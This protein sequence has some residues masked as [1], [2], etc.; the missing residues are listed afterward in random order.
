MWP[1]SQPPQEKMLQTMGSQH[2]DVFFVIYGHWFLHLSKLVCFHDLTPFCGVRK[3]SKRIFMSWL[4]IVLQEETFNSELFPMDFINSE[5]PSNTLFRF[6][7]LYFMFMGVSPACMSVH[8]VYAWYL[9]TSEEGIGS[10]GTGV[11]YEWATMCAGNQS[12]AF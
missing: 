5:K 6:I 8:H 7:Y 9:R 11:T 10:P 12:S 3:C 1:I 4:C 2:V